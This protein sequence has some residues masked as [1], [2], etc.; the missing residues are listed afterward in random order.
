[1]I[2]F[3]ELINSNI[4]LSIRKKVESFYK[5]TQAIADFAKAMMIP[6]LKGQLNLDKK[7]EAI[8]GTYFRMY[9]WIQSMVV[10]NGCVH[11]QGAGAAAPR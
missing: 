6:V 1:M 10:M 5:G 3:E 4:D 11:F 7:K 2:T 9:A 8:V